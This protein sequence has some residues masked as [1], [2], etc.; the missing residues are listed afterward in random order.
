[1]KDL[2]TWLRQRRCLERGTSVGRIRWI[3]NVDEDSVTKQQ[4]DGMWCCISL[5]AWLSI[6]MAYSY[7]STDFFLPPEYAPLRLV[8]LVPDS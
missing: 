2:S 7:F 5:R 4:G 3:K 8:P 1:M 6:A